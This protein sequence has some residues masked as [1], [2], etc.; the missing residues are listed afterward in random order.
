[1]SNIYNRISNQYPYNV[2][3][4]YTD[5]SSPT[6]SCS[7]LKCPPD[8]NLKHIIFND[9][10]LSIIQGWET[11]LNFS[12]AEF[13]KTIDI[14]MEMEFIV[15]NHEDDLYSTVSTAIANRYATFACVFPQYIKTS[16]EQANWTLEYRHTG[17]DTWKPIG[18]ILMLDSLEAN[19]IVNIEFRNHTG[20]EIPV[21]ILYAA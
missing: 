2:V 18:R 14:H 4:V 11:K 13:F 9:N 19:P 8:N 1:M 6:G 20:V 21:K 16:L 17:D 5:P 7:V 15:E 10:N 12:L 3:P